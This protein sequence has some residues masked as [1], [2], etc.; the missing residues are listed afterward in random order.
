MRAARSKARGGSCIVLSIIV[1]SIMAPSTDAVLYRMIGSASSMASSLGLGGMLKG[2]K[3][4]SKVLGIVDS[5]L[6]A[7]GLRGGES[8]AVAKCCRLV[9]AAHL[10]TEPLAPSPLFF[11]LRPL[12]DL[13]S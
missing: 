9:K 3:G 5:G 10:R 12:E 2:F 11:K 13:P 8:D 7:A 4:A 6:A 1:T